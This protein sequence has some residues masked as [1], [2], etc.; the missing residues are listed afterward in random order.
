PARLQQV[1]WNLIKNAIKFTLLAG[2]ITLRSSNPEKNWFRLEVIDSGVGIATD[3]LSKIFDPFQQAG[4]TAAGGLGLGLTIS[5]AIVELHGGRIA[6]FSSG[7]DH[8]ASFVIEL[9]NML[10]SSAEPS[11]IQ[12]EHTA[13]EAAATEE[14][15]TRNRI[16]LVDDHLDTVRGM[17]LL[18]E[19]SGYLVTTAESVSDALRIADHQVFDLLVSDIALPDGKGEDLIR[20]LRAKGHDFPGIALSGYGAEEDRACSRAAGFAV[21][22][23]KPVLPEQLLACIDQLL[24]RAGSAS[25]S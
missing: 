24:S 7:L 23:V 20:R 22:L 25:G 11:P 8:G 6:A 14:V 10:P 9:P 21:H 3:A 19:R 2:E 18:L 1:F 12:I 4:S 5:K 13:S 16:L 15:T 17:Q